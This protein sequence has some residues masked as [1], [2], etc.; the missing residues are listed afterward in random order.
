MSV[1]GT[2][3]W[4]FQGSDG[5]RSSGTDTYNPVF[6]LS[7]RQYISGRDVNITGPISIWFWIPTNVTVGDVVE[8]LDEPLTVTAL[9]ATTWL[10]AM[11]RSAI[12]LTGSGQYPRDDEYGTYTATYHDEYYFDRESGFVVA[13][14]FTE[15]DVGSWQGEPASFR[16]RA[17]LFVTASSYPIPLELLT[18][19]L[20]YLGI[21][22]AVVLVVAGVIRVRRGPSRF[23]VGSKDFPTSVRIRRAKTPADVVNLVPD[24]S[25]FLG[26]FLPVFAERSIAEGD[27][28]VLALADRRIMGM[29]LLDRESGMGSLFATD[30]RVAQVLGKRL[31][32]RDFFADAA[33]PGRLLRATEMDRFTILQLRN[34]QARDYDTALVRPMSADDL[35]AVVAIAEAVYRGRARRFLQSSFQAGD[36]GF[37]ATSGGRVVGFGFAMVVGPVARLHTLTVDAAY[38]A[39]GIG[40]EIMNARLSTL[41]AL[42][43]ERV[44]V[45]ISKNN[46]ASLR[47]ATKAGFVPV[48]DT[49][50]YSRRPEMAPMAI[51]RQT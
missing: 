40:T 15:Q 39:Q 21:P 23:N 4:S 7:T 37:V 32:M 41:A 25:P 46:A 26:P 50:Y 44:L 31:R 11:P 12:L 34:P 8:V 47:I 3:S 43:V 38:R 22:A 24:G 29:V 16:Y 10:G 6:S 9:S 1:L 20:V 17:E 48:G 2:G 49:V 51:Q 30:E 28:V 36:L 33:L 27:P 35:P 14:R 13:E 19:S 5:T 45:E 42:G 18:F